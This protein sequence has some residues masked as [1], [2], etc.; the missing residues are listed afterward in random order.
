MKR[1]IIIGPAYPL[2]GG[3]VN[4][5]ERLAKQFKDEGHY[6]AVYSFSFL[7]PKFLFPGKSQHKTEP[8]TGNIEIIRC[9]NSINPINWLRVAYAILWI[10]RPHIV[11]VNCWLPLLAPCLG[12]IMRILKGKTKIVGIAHNIKPHEKRPF[13]KQLI[14]YF[15]KPVSSWIYMSEKVKADLVQFDNIE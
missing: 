11:V 13:D 12:T 1:I 8:F 6:C 4:F 15:C 5:T 9:I 7:Y 3:I 2:K 14:R 10:E